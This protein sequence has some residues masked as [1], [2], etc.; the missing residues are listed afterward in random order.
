MP[1]NQRVSQWQHSGRLSRGTHAY[2]G[3]NGV[4]GGVCQGHRPRV[5]LP[6]WRQVPENIIH[7]GGLG[8][9]G[10]QDRAVA[11]AGPMAS[12]QEEGMQ[13]N[14]VRLADSFG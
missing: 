5:A 3:A 4:V 14:V 9:G 2:P 11:L 8:D 13:D 7:S 1:A 10:I 6:E 12:T